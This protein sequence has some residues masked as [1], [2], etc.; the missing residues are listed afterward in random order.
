MT[1]GQVGQPP[2]THL[3]TDKAFN[4]TT[5]TYVAT[6]SPAWEQHLCLILLFTAHPGMDDKK[7]ATIHTTSSTILPSTPPRGIRQ[8]PPRPGFLGLSIIH[9]SSTPSATSRL[10]H[11]HRRSTK[12]QRPHVNHRGSHARHRTQGISLS[13][14]RRHHDTP[15]D[16]RHSQMHVATATS[17]ASTAP[18]HLQGTALGFLGHFGLPLTL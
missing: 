9:S 2:L 16:G 12:E 6:A 1:R 10:G 18:S 7:A 5:S 14:H 4:A 15:N 11:E 17:I 13:R 8:Q 3:L